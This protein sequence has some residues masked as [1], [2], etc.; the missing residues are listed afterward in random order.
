MNRLVQ[1]S[2]CMERL[3]TRGGAVKEAVGR[4]F[5]PPV[6]ARL[7]ARRLRD[8]HTLRRAASYAIPP[9]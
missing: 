9:A 8:L 4:A 1:R 6:A 5:G 2:R 3:E 7:S